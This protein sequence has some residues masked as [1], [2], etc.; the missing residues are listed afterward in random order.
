VGSSSSSNSGRATNAQAINTRRFSP[1]D[2]AVNSLS[3]KV[4]GADLLESLGCR[5]AVLPEYLVVRKYT[6]AGEEPRHHRLESVYAPTMRPQG[7]GMVEF[8]RNKPHA[9]RSEATSQRARPRILT[10]G[11]SPAGASG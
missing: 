9:R 8:A 3:L 6:L 7:K 2:I 11:V 5:R 1:A 10:G 4:G